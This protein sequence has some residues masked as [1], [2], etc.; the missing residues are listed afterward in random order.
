MN[1]GMWQP[2]GPSPWIAATFWELYFKPLYHPLAPP[3]H[4]GSLTPAWGSCGF[5]CV[6][7]FPILL[8]LL[9]VLWNISPLLHS[10]KDTGC[11]S[12]MQEISLQKHSV[13][14][15][16]KYIAGLLSS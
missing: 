16:F 1:R 11:L 10:N 14:W 13:L 9:L 7:V 6:H 4:S 15:G 2:G 12:L 8:K 5:H 3:G